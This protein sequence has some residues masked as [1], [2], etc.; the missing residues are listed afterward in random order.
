MR[1]RPGQRPLSSAAPH[2]KAFTQPSLLIQTLPLLSRA[3]SVVGRGAAS[4]SR[5]PG[6][7]LTRWTRP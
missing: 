1:L 3:A 2:G 4:L 5:P 6:L 7:S